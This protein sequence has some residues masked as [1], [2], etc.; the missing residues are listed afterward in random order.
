MIGIIGNLF[1]HLATLKCIIFSCILSLWFWM[2][3][4]YQWFID[5]IN[6]ST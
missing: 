6:G 4:G 5:V 3:G 2:N 1:D